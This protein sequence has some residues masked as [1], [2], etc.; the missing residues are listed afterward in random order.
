MGY[1]KIHNKGDWRHEEAVASKAVSPGMLCE[2]VTDGRV[3]YHSTQ[4]GRAERLVAVE[5]ALQGR[6]VA[7]AYSVGDQVMLSV[8]EPGTVMNMLIAAGQNADPGEEVISAGDGTLI[9]IGSQ[10]SAAI[11]VQVIGRIDASEAA[12]TT[13]AANTLKAVRF[14]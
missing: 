8:V 3:Q 4:G 12:F 14:V 13:L 9:V 11:N 5:D 1:T 2:I 6:G 7:T 10:A